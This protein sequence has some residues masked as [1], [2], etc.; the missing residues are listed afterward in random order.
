MC[1]IR[2]ATS[3]LPFCIHR[4]ATS[5]NGELPLAEQAANGEVADS[6]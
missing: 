6:R 4:T 5:W 1:F 2:S 3:V